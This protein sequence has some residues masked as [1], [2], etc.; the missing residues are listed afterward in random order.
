MR[1]GYSN[2]DYLNAQVARFGGNISRTAQFVGMERSALHRKLRSLGMLERERDG[3][4]TDDGDAEADA[5]PCRRKQA[6]RPMKIIVCGAGQV[7]A[8]I[9]R[10]LANEAND[11][12]VIDSDRGGRAA[13]LRLGRREGDRGKRIAA[14]RA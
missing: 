4:G 6:E 2:G 7:G 11:V 13:V 12:T 9:A 1:A 10:Q 14:R 3:Q 5:N 8:S